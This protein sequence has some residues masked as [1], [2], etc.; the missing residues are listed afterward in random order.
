MCA[1][2]VVGLGRSGHAGD[3]EGRSKEPSNCSVSTPYI[4]CLD[5][6]GAMTV[7]DKFA[8]T[9]TAN[10]ALYAICESYFQS[11]LSAGDLVS[12]TEKCIKLGLQRDILSGCN[13]RIYLITA[14]GMYTRDIV[15]FDV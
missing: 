9:G 11:E 8:V 15:T 13:V 2:V 3:A 12:L 4:C 1:P 6:L 14:D 10:H 5:G 7:T